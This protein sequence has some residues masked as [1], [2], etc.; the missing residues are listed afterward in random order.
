M[1]DH[2]VLTVLFVSLSIFVFF[3]YCLGHSYDGLVAYELETFRFDNATRTVL[4]HVLYD[5]FADFASVQLQF[6]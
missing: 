6:G 1:T 5:Q 3:K 2:S 4:K